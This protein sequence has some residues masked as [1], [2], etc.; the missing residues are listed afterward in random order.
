MD[1]VGGMAA[2]LALCEDA[3]AYDDVL[4]VMAAEDEAARIRQAEAR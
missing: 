2:Y 3:R 1:R 4:I